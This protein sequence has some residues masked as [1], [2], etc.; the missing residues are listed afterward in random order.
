[1]AV[2]EAK[3]VCKSFLRSKKS[4]DTFT[5]VKPV[6]LAVHA[7]ELVVVT[8]HSG[9]GKS[10]LL[11]MMAGMLEPTGGKVELD[12][13]D[14]YAL[15]DEERSRLRNEKIGFVPQGH[16]ALLSLTV[17]ENVLFP[18]VLYGTAEPYVERA[19]SLLAHVGLV[20]LAE[21]KPNELSGGELRRMAVARAL[22]MQ[23]AVLL[24]DEP[25]AGLDSENA[26][27][28]HKLYRQAADEGAAVLLVT[29]EQG[30]EQFADRVLHM[31]DG[32]FQ[33]GQ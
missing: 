24:A 33:D 11:S 25:T 18:A 26:Q 30:F 10:T 3:G 27:V 17:V 12:G 4:A 23:P 9:S 29:H 22:L 7:G 20:E 13:V 1:M 31:E 28:V 14:L 5:V 16:T 2:I 8:G 15:G 19:M 21:A 6:D 32:S